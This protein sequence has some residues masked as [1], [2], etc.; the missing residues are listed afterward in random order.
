M[1]R[2]YERI[3]MAAYRYADVHEPEPVLREG[4]QT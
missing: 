2:D 3:Y 4:V 1:A